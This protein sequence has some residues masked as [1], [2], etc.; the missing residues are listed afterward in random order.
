M[1][2]LISSHQPPVVELRGY[3]LKVRF[4]F[5]ADEKKEMEETEKTPKAGSPFLQ[6]FLDRAREER[7]K[8]EGTRP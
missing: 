3:N 7:L 8:K 6:R 2:E 1:L 4:L 5:A